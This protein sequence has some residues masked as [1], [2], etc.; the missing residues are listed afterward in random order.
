MFGKRAIKATSESAGE[1][2]TA[3][4][5]NG[6]RRNK[7]SSS[8]GAACSADRKPARAGPDHLGWQEVR[9]SCEAGKR[10]RRKGP[11][12]GDSVRIGGL[13]RATYTGSLTGATNL[14]RLRRDRA[15]EEQTGCGH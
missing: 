13:Y 15:R 5:H 7:G 3:C 14:V 2:A 12:C 4:I 10:R 9:I 6:T 11:Q 8:D 1:V